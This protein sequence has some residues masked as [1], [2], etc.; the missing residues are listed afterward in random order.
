MY[1]IAPWPL[2]HRQCAACTLMNTIYLILEI[3]RLIVV[4]CLYMK[5]M[6]RRK[7]K[8]QD[9]SCMA[10]R[11]TQFIVS[12][13]NAHQNDRWEKYVISRWRL[14]SYVCKQC[15]WRRVSFAHFYIWIDRYTY[16]YIYMEEVREKHIHHIEIYLYIYSSKWWWWW[17]RCC[18]CHCLVMKLHF[19]GASVKM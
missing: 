5:K 16:I 19:F 7:Q 9:E 11:K 17:W 4:Q 14:F 6:S 15:A 12:G 18:C 13:I 1:R 8:K 2:N 10:E 3:K